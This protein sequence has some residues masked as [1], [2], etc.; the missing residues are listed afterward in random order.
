MKKE[1][2]REKGRRKK[3]SKRK[4]DEG[5]KSSAKEYDYFIVLGT[6]KQ[7]NIQT[8]QGKENAGKKEKEKEKKT[9]GNVK[10]LFLNKIIMFGTHNL[11]L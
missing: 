11:F 9:E 7:P 4:G 1:R 10:N 2:R 3:G 6:N 5:V 8:K